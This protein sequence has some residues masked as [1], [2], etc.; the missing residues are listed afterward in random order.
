MH[1]GLAVL[2]RDGDPLVTGRRIGLLTHPA[3]IDAQLRSTADLLAADP[4]WELAA[5]FG[6]E[7]GIRGDAQA[8]APVGSATDAATGLPV[9]SLYG[10][11]EVPAAGMLAGLDTVVIDLQDIGVRYFTYPAT[12]LGVVE[13]AAA[14]GVAVVILDRPNPLSGALV[15]GGGLREGLRSLVGVHDVPIRHGLTLGELARLVA[16]ARSL[17]LPAVVRMEGWDR[18]WWHDATGLPWI[19][20]SPNLPTLDAVTFYPGTCLLE[21]TNLSEGRGTTRPFEQVGA[22]WLDPRRFTDAFNERGCAGVRARPSTFVPTFSKHAGTACGGIQLHLTDRAAL[23]P[24]EVGLT[25]LSVARALSEDE[26]E[27]IDAS[28]D[29]LSGDPAVREA[30]ASGTD[31]AALIAR[32]RANATGFSR[33]RRP[34]LLYPEADAATV[35]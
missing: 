22:P 33:E 31:P 16:A 27:W 7:H 9:H 14:A 13:A 30:L 23:R 19:P 12:V 5:L 28:F 15:E 24:T 20:P 32:S 17:P 6:P 34:W 8:G 26:L 10:A 21:G 3:G 2:L 11:T 35:S 1:S 25:V 4:R 18:A 29:R